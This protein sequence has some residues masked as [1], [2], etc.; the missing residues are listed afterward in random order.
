MLDK[1]DTGNLDTAWEEVDE[2]RGQTND[3]EADDLEK[4]I[5]KNQIKSHNFT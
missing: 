1:T 5:D 2:M 4:V 3:D